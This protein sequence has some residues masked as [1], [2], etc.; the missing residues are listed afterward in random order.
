MGYPRL[1]SV[2]D[3]SPKM[4]MTGTESSLMIVPVPTL[5]PNVAEEDT[6]ERATVKVSSDSYVRSPLT[7]TVMVL[8][9]SPGRRLSRMGR[10][11]TT[12]PSSVVPLITVR[13][14][15][16]VS[17]LGAEGRGEAEELIAELCRV[18]LGEREGE[19]PQR[20]A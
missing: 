9:T 16:I 4:D 14:K 2:T 18:P 11:G 19:T 15:L 13:V 20:R 3:V 5:F 1:P 8:V 12:S 6:P 17:E 7:S 10:V